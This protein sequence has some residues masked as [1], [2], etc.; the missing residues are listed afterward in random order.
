MLLG[1]ID[2]NKSIDNVSYFNILF[3]IN[4]DYLTIL[5]NMKQM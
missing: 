3:T 4:Y 5:N 2:R 1:R